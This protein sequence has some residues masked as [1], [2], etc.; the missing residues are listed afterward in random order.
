MTCRVCGGSMT[1]DRHAETEAPV[2]R[3]E[4]R[5]VESVRRPAVVAFCN[6]CEHAEELRGDERQRN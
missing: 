5:K 4:T 1:I 3:V 6:H 2:Y